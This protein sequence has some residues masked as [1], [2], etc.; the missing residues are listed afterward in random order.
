MGLY[1]KLGNWFDKKIMERL[2]GSI[3]RRLIDLAAGALLASTI[4]AISAVGRWVSDNH[5]ELEGLLAGVVLL[6]ISFLWSTMQKKS[7]VKLIK[8]QERKIAYQDDKIQRRG[9]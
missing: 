8:E 1:K 3:S 2:A 9:L 6:A 5:V 4:P 7:D